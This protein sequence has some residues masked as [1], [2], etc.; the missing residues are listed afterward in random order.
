MSDFNYSPAPS[1][2]GVKAWECVSKVKKGSKEQN[3]GKLVLGQKAEKLSCCAPPVAFT[4]GSEGVE[5]SLPK[6]FLANLK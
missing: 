3:T 2:I 5:V 6:V 4:S 1:L